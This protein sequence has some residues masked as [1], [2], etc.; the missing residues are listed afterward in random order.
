MKLTPHSVTTYLEKPKIYTHLCINRSETS[1]GR[2]KRKKKKQQNTN[3]AVIHLYTPVQMVEKL[4]K[5][6]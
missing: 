1:C 3:K 4:K 5:K 6:C 2:R